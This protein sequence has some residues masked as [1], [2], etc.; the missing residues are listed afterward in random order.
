MG[1]ISRFGSLVAMLSARLSAFSKETCFRDP[2]L[3][4]DLSGLPGGGAGGRRDRGSEET[5]GSVPC[6]PVGAA[7]VS[8]RMNEAALFTSKCF[9]CDSPAGSCWG[10]KSSPSLRSGRRPPVLLPKAAVLQEQ[11]R[12]F[13]VGNQTT[14]SPC[15]SQP[16]LSRA[17]PEELPQNF[18][19]GRW[20]P[21]GP[22]GPRASRAPAAVGGGDNWARSPSYL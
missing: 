7:G 2:R 12:A 19:R 21:D 3:T 15:L 6:E 11:E 20:S 8:C 9:S 16:Q 14:V 13:R 5:Q 10:V 22:D 17:G 1:G 18:G 4:A